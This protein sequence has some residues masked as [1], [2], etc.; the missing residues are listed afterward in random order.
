[1]IGRHPR[2]DDFAPGY[3]FLT[4]RWGYDPITGFGSS[5]RRA[6]LLCRVV[7]RGDMTFSYEDQH[8]TIREGR[9][10][11]MDRPD[12][13]KDERFMGINIEWGG[14]LPDAPFEEIAVLAD[15]MMRQ[16]WRDRPLLLLCESVDAEGG[17]VCR[18][19]C[20][21]TTTGR[22]RDRHDEEPLAGT[23]IGDAFLLDDRVRLAPGCDRGVRGEDLR[24]VVR[25]I[26]ETGDLLAAIR[27]TG[28]NDPV[29]TIVE[30]NVLRI[31][32]GMDET[33]V[34]RWM[35]PV[36]RRDGEIGPADL[37]LAGI[38]DIEDERCRA[39]ARLEPDEVIVIAVPTPN[40]E[41]H[42]A[43]L[44]KS[45]IRLHEDDTVDD[46][47]WNRAID[48]GVHIGSDVRWFDAGED[49]AEWDASFG[50]A[51]MADLER[52]GLSLEEV[53]GNWSEYAERDVTPQEIEAMLAPSPGATTTI[54]AG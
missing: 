33:A 22:R 12:L 19:V 8:G 40:G 54:A 25:T 45:G 11:Q 7:S 49:G 16:G 52:H 3:R 6:G 1:M 24:E 47:L 21:K 4:S 48:A 35:P 38:D 44:S 15:L 39:I 23:T 53:A 17:A 10:R 20:Q 28:T 9:L 31:R 43:H 41:L 29:F 51:T 36:E 37:A 32:G 26:P 2:N 42:N 5:S 14:P 18:V 13:G 46:E 30:A 27:I 34:G 50:R